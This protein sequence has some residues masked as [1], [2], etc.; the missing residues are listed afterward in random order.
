MLIDRD[1]LL[2]EKLGEVPSRPVLARAR[3][4]LRKELAI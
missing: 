2:E 3:F 1:C 4:D